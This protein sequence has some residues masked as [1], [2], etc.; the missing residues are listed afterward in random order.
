M[1]KSDVGSLVDWMYWVNHRLLDA[2]DGLTQEEFV[3]ASTVTT[4]SLRETLVHELDVER[5]WREILTG[6]APDEDL[7]TDDYPDVASLREHW[8]RDEAA[9][10]DWRASLSDADVEIEVG[11]AITGDRQPLWKF[12]VHVVTHAAQQQA[13]AATLLTLAGRSPGEFDYLEFL[14]PRAR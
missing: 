5:S 12:L 1:N 4:R 14:A 10:R 7:R 6:G 3:A 9:M 8:T 2:A 11:A 13:D